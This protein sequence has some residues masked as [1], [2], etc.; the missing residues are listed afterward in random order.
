[1]PITNSNRLAG[2][3]TAGAVF[4]FTFKVFPADSNPSSTNDL[5]ITQVN[6]LGVPSIMQLGTDYTVVINADQDNNPGGSITR[7]AGSLNGTGL[8]WTATTNLDYI[9]PVAITNLGGFFPKVITDALDRLTILVQQ[10]AAQIG[11]AIKIPLSDGAISSTLPPKAQRVG[12]ALVFDANGAPGVSE[13]PFNDQGATAAAASA[14]AA[15]ASQNAAGS[16]ASAASASATLANNAKADAVTAR[17]QAVAAVGA[18]KVTANDTTAGNLFAKLLASTSF[19]RVVGNPGG[20]ETLTF[21]LVPATPTVLGGQFAA[22]ANALANRTPGF[23][24]QAHQLGRQLPFM[25]SAAQDG[26]AEFSSI[27]ITADGKLLYTGR[28]TYAAQGMGTGDIETHGYNEII[29]PVDYDYKVVQAIMHYRYGAALLDN[30]DVYAWGTTVTGSIGP[31]NQDF[32]VKVPFPEPIGKIWNAANSGGYY[33]NY[34]GLVA[35][36]KNTLNCYSMGFNAQGQAGGGAG[37]T[38]SPKTAPVQFSAQYE[39][40]FPLVDGFGYVYARDADKKMWG[41]GNGQGNS[42]GNQSANVTSTTYPSRVQLINLPQTNVEFVTDIVSKIRD[43]TGT[44]GEQAFI[45]KGAITNLGSVWH[46]G[47]HGTATAGGMGFPAGTTPGLITQDVPAPQRLLGAG[48]AVIGGRTPA[49][50]FNLT[51]Y[52]NRSFAIVTTDKTLYTYGF[53]D[54]SATPIGQGITGAGTAT[55]GVRT[56]AIP[57]PESGDANTFVGT[58]EQVLT[59]LSESNGAEW[60]AVRLSNGRVYACG[61]NANG[62]LGVGDLVNTNGVFRLVRA[63]RNRKIVHIFLSGWGDIGSIGMVDDKGQV[64]NSGNNQYCCKGIT[65][66]GNVTMAQHKRSLVL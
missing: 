63:S 3:F 33:G 15:L 32:P 35:M 31:T 34:G 61:Y 57:V 47:F 30:G 9:Q 51:S 62:N 53:V 12:R 14:A 28:G 37:D 26:S 19:T 49:K 13:Q 22:D 21:N 52:I 38:A 65:N 42:L 58:V 18:V 5:V 66:P 40:L 45:T 60:C 25:V 4:P 23:S 29:M 50:L 16:S 44:T 56:P 17:D 27:A 59:P 24:V 48:D 43:A 11:N 7:L 64:W 36:A 6:A 20:N 54:N 46:W 41:W 8:T 1:M 39:A 2:P 10:A 55:T